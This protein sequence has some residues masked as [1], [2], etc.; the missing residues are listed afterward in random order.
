MRIDGR[1]EEEIESVTKWAMND[2]FWCKNIL[3]GRKLRE[4]FDQLYISMVTQ[5]DSPKAK[6]ESEAKEKADRIQRNIQWAE[7]YF[8]DGDI[9]IG[10]MRLSMKSNGIE[11]KGNRGYKLVGFAEHGFAEQIK[12]IHTKMKG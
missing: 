9:K 4:K 10:I 2:S 7:D 3:S 8:K 1:S 11:I 5:K 12:S 6:V